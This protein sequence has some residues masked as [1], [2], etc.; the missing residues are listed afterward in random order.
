M[1]EQQL[2][3]ELRRV[4]EQ[5]DKAREALKGMLHE[6][7]KFTRY[8]SPIAKASNENVNRAR[9]VLRAVGP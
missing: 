6:W 8:G 5:R 7:D 3:A 9:D 2:I 4:T 1:N